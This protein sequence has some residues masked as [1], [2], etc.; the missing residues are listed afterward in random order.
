MTGA[1]RTSMRFA[2]RN[3]R[4]CC[5]GPVRSYAVLMTQ[6]GLD[7]LFNPAKRH[8]DEE[9][10]RLQ[11]TREEIGDSSGGNRIDLE[12]GKV[13]IKRKK[14]EPT[15]MSAEMS[16]ETSADPTRERGEVEHEAGDTHVE[17]TAQT[18][19]MPTAESAVAE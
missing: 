16:A 19:N 9:K 4:P 13:V 8:M 3:L 18:E 12:S 2:A 6:W 10:R 11:S 1:R 15:E 17:Q 14:A 7:T 5:A